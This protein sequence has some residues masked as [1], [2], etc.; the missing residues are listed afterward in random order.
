MEKTDYIQLF[1]KFLLKQASAEEIQ[2]LIQWLKSEGSFQ[3]WAD[4]EWNAAASEMD[5]KLQRQLFGQIKEKISQIDRTCL[6]EKENRPRKFYLWFARVASVILLLLMTGL[7]VHYYTMSQMIMPDMIVSVEKGQKANVV[8]PD[9]SKVWVNSDSRLSYGS[10]FN[11]KERVLSLEGE[12]YFEVTP[13]KDRPFIVETDELAVRALGTSFN[14]KSYEEEKDASTVLMTGKV[15]VTSDY[16]RLVLNPNERIV[17]NK[18][19][20]HMEKST[21]ENTGD[22]INWKYN[23]LT[24]NGETFEN[25]VHTLE[26]YYNTRIV[27]ESETLKKY[28]FTGTPG[29]TSLES[30]LQI[31][32][33]T[34]PLSYEVR[35]SMIILRENVKQKAY[36]EKA[37]K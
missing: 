17:F 33:L 23:A 14:V 15:E 1:D 8:L 24:F 30:I 31:L 35:D 2:V 21:V 16:D 34:S 6:P 20:G 13:D 12:A 3:D 22:Y 36:Y 27:F 4:E 18:Q 29:N 5:T 7:S 25:I 10:R 32:S 11:Q 9:G 37:L 26:R 19:T 28:R